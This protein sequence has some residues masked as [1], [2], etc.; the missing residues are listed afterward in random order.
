M[1]AMSTSTPKSPSLLFLIVPV[2]VLAIFGFFGARYML[3]THADKTLDRLAVVWPAI[4]T[5]PE[6]ERAF[7]V[8]LALICNVAER[9]AVRAEVVACL[10]SSAE[11]MTPAPTG[12]LEGLLR[13]APQAP[14]QR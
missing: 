10:R 11:K 5:M 13:Q 1:Q 4:E 14:A 9:E 3:K 6:P 2:V 12:R 7:L 8:E